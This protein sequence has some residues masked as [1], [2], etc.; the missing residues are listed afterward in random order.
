[1]QNIVMHMI[2]A[3]QRLTKHVP[4]V[5]LSTIEG[6]PLPGNRRVPWTEMEL[7]HV[8]AATNKCRITLTVEDG[9]LY[10]VHPTVIKGEHVIDSFINKKSVMM[11]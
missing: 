11:Q 7:T 4:E 5:K 1:M 2:T 8:Y 3:R 6:C 10:S 9:D